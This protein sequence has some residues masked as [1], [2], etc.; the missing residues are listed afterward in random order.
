M[1]WVVCLA[2]AILGGLVAVV[3]LCG[4]VLLAAWIAGKRE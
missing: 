2:S 1:I 3:G 4:T